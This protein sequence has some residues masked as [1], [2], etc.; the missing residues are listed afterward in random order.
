MHDYNR[1]DD[2]S[3]RGWTRKQP[4]RNGAP[5]SIIVGILLVGAVAASLVACNARPAAGAAIEASPI[6]TAV[7]GDAP[8]PRDQRVHLPVIATR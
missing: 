3:M 7:I 1:H 4:R 2:V 6:P 5:V 8:D